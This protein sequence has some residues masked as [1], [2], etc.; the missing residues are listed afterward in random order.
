M[1]IYKRIVLVLVIMV[2]ITCLVG[3]GKKAFTLVGSWDHN[4]FVYTFNSDKTGNYNSLGTILEF[5]YEDDGEKVTLHYK[6]STME[7]VYEYKIEDN[8]LIIKDSFGKDVEYI[9]K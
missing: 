1:N 2:G 8:K 3:C 5:G 7:N 4:G 6:N 9:R